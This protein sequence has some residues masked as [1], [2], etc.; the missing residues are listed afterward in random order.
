MMDYKSI[1]LHLFSI[2]TEVPFSVET[3]NGNII[4]DGKTILF[5]IDEKEYKADWWKK[6]TP[7][8]GIKENVKVPPGKIPNITKETSSTYGRLLL[9]HLLLV[10]HF[11]D[12]IPYQNGNWLS[13]KLINKVMDIVATDDNISSEEAHSFVNATQFITGLT[14][15]CVPSA[16]EKSLSTDPKIKAKRKELLEKYKDTLDD[17]ATVSKIEQ[18]LIAMDKQWLKGDPSEG[19]YLSS[20]SYNIVRKKAH[21]MYGG[22][23][24]FLN[25]N[26]MTLIPKSLDEG[27]DMD[28]LPEMINSLRDGAYSRGGAT[29]IGGVKVK[30]FQQ[31]FQNA[32][33]SM[34]DCG[35]NLGLRYSVTQLNHKF[36]I[37]RQLINGKEL[38]SENIKSFIGKDIN[39]RSPMYC[40]A[41]QTDYCEICS[42]K[43]VSEH[44]NAINMLAAS[45]G[46]VFMLREMA[47]TH[48]KELLTVS[49]PLKDLLS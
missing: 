31:V 5:K 26:K 19:F 38:T 13:D 39:I 3:E 37:G 14:Q 42:G 47:K 33:I 29:A 27:W 46:S 21:V 18:E 17:P 25:E 23:R 22:E 30:M 4:S 10:A 34:P 41:A 12:K 45:I 44:P 11:V 24:D 35:T 28:H 49:F 15:I 20:K 8:Y 7:L 32:R 43:K 48:G 16:S 1:I 6:N 40:N 9:N 36:F 2:K